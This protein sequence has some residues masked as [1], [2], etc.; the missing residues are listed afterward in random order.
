MTENKTCSIITWYRLTIFCWPVCLTTGEVTLALCTGP[1]FSAVEPMIGVSV[2]GCVCL[3]VCV[4]VGVCE[5]G[6]TEPDDTA[7]PPE[8]LTKQ[9]SCPLTARH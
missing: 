1:G 8:H 7:F 9:E 2:G 6:Q 4:Y 3:C 5:Q